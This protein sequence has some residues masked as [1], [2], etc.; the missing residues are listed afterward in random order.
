MTKIKDP[1]GRAKKKVLTPRLDGFGAE[2]S[3]AVIKP[4]TAA[5]SAEDA[6]VPQQNYS[7][8]KT[9]LNKKNLHGEFEKKI[10]NVVTMRSG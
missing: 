4:F 8:S 2:D 5:I 3:T 6:D 7:Q 9:K 1:G 10:V